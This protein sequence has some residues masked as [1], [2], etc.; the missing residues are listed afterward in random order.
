MK[1]MSFSAL[2]AFAL[3][4]LISTPVLAG[5]LGMRDEGA[6]IYTGPSVAYQM[7]TFTINQNTVSCGVGTVSAG[8][9]QYGPFEMLMYSL[10]V[11]SYT[12]HR[13]V[14][15]YIEVTGKMRSITR[16][17][18]NIVEDTDGSLGGVPPHDYIAIGEDRDPPQKDRFTVHFAT[19]FW[20]PSNP[21]C[22]P[23]NLVEGW[24]QFGD[25]A[26]LG[27]IV[28]QGQQF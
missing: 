10:S 9:E 24:C 1:R 26:I 15:R 12:V 7:S 22:T 27:N 18:E 2:L 6:G 16:V 4:A 20:N 17:A 13:D 28:V 11:D 5:Q 25:E 23:S 19:P 14:P 21:L 8:P 3:I